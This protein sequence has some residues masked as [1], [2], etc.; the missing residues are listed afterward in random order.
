MAYA[1]RLRRLEIRSD[2]SLSTELLCF[3][4]PIISFDWGE[5]QVR[6]RNDART[7]PRTGDL[8]DP[9]G[10]EIALDSVWASSAGSLADDAGNPERLLVEVRKEAKHVRRGRESVAYHQVAYHQQLPDAQRRLYP[11]I[12]RWW[13]DVYT[14]PSCIVPLPPYFIYRARYILP[15]MVCSPEGEYLR[16]LWMRSVLPWSSPVGV[17]TFPRRNISTLGLDG[18]LAQSRYSRVH[19]EQR[20]QDHDSPAWNRKFQEHVVR[21]RDKGRP[22]EVEFRTEHVRVYPAFRLTPREVLPMG[23][24]SLPKLGG[25]TANQGA[26]ADPM[27]VITQGQSLPT[28][29]PASDPTVTVTADSP[30]TDNHASVDPRDSN[31]DPGDTPR[32]WYQRYEGG[33]VDPGDPGAVLEWGGIGHGPRSPIGDQ[34]EE[35]EDI[36]GS[37]TVAWPPRPTGPALRSAPAVIQEVAYS[38]QRKLREA[39]L[40]HLLE[41]YSHGDLG[42]ERGPVREEA[43]VEMVRHAD[44]LQRHSAAEVTRLR[45]RIEDL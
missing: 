32:G 18:L 13:T 27:Q 16:W 37:G 19:V 6:V 42:L 4:R 5:S 1:D 23:R 40:G 17:A 36:I 35:E 3:N 15:E 29:E 43:V 28:P 45:Q 21:R 26:P 39:G 20:F 31:P 34:E 30:L 2:A 7:Y 38:L 33:R 8:A 22:A 9:S 10:G 24:W 12:P 14:F 11:A 44:E 41:Y 25:E